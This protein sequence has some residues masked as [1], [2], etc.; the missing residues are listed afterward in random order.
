MKFVQKQFPV[1]SSNCNR[2]DMTYARTLRNIKKGEEL[3]VE[4]SSSY[5]FRSA[6]PAGKF[7]VR[8][9]NIE[10]PVHF[11]TMLL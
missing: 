1:R 2:R 11:H 9:R 5:H 3:F 6:P 7:R 4:Y 8:R 10:Y